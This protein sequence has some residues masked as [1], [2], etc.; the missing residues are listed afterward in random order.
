[1]KFLFATLSIS[2]LAATTVGS[3]SPVVGMH[4]LKIS[5]AGERTRLVS[6]PFLRTAEAYGRLDGVQIRPTAGEHP[7]LIDHEAAFSELDEDAVYILRITAGAAAGDWFLLDEV[8]DNGR[9]VTVRDDGLAALAA[10]LQGNESFAIHSL[11][12]LEELFPVDSDLFPSAPIDLAAMQVHFFDGEDFNR[13]WRSDGT[14]TAHRGWTFARN[15]QLEDA[16]KVAVLPG[17][18]FLSVFPQ[19]SSEVAIQVNGVIPEAGLTVPVYSGYNYVSVKYSGATSGGLPALADYLEI[20]GLKGS[21]FDGGT[22]RES[23]DLVLALSEA[24]GTLL[25]GFFYDEDAGLFLPVGAE[26]LEI[27]LEDV[28]PGR[29]FVI[30]NR[31]EPYLWRANSNP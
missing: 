16:N 20:I 27:G 24:E 13:Y 18:S 4:K 29:G 30:Y 26:S 28:G 7:T 22:S 19:A 12:T 6:V 14:L 17:T 2:I 11:F 9:S 1:M 15:G 8:G 5:E 31:G 25:P 21:G 10:D 23:S 3:A